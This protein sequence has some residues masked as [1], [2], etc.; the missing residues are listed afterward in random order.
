MQWHLNSIY[1]LNSNWININNQ[2]TMSRSHISIEGP[3]EPTAFTQLW[4]K[5]HQISLETH[6]SHLFDYFSATTQISSHISLLAGQLTTNTHTHSPHTS[7][8][9]SHRCSLHHC[10]F[11]QDSPHKYH[12]ISLSCPNGLEMMDLKI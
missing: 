1:S 2:H 9:L 3:I 4:K 5:K 7:L 11:R 8:S 12:L 6:Q 10:F